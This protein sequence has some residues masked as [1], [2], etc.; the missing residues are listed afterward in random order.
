MKFKYQART[1]EG[2][3]QVG[4]VEAGSRESAANIL[5]G[6]ELYI[7][8]IESAEKKS[9]YDAIANIFSRVRRKDMM[10]FTRQL[11]T[12]LEAR[13]PLNTA[14][15]TLREQTTHLVLKEAVYQIAEDVDAGLSLS[16]AMER[17][18]EIFPSFYVEMIRASEL[19]GNLSEV[20]GFL[21]DYTEKE[22]VL[23]SKAASA[24]IYPTIVVTLFLA[25][26]FIM[27]TFVF[28]Q[29]GP[30]F[31]QSGVNLPIYTRILLGAGKFLGTW[32]PA[33]I[34]ALFV[35]AIII[36]DYATT[37][38]GKA[39]VDDAK[40]KLP[41]LS[42]IFM[43]LTMARFSNAAALLIHGGIPV[44]QTL[45]IIG[46]MVGN[47]LYRDIIHEVAESVRQGELLSQAMAKYPEYFPPL[48]GQMV[49][50]G[51]Q[52]GKLEQVFTR[53]SAFY[54]RETDSVVNS[55]VDLIQPILIVGIGILVALLFA[56]IL[57]PLY[58]LTTS[59]GV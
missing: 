14:L 38:E 8:Q 9:F 55:I 39:M 16:Q 49:A 19:T 40:I 7:L 57:I 35:F 59:I 5:A 32:W 58:S 48:V 44:A 21:A 46:H 26:G 1:K 50:V 33:V 27:V 15:K 29:I 43:P 23:A 31:E 6:H 45:E 20:S 24:L 34:I 25:V 51:E 47:I 2:E 13:L 11:A 36:F 28:P 12:L 54:N 37:S 22:A 17:Q 18:G 30:I 3:M 41:L 42:K 56:S 53:L 52:T 4:F 10:V